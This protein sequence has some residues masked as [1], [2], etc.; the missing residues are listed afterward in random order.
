[1]ERCC[2]A[3]F[4]CSSCSHFAVTRCRATGGRD[5]DLSQT[6]MLSCCLADMMMLFHGRMRCEGDVPARGQGQIGHQ[7]L[8]IEVS[9]FPQA[10][11]TRRVCLHA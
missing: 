11:Q 6:P 5:L 10:A 3:I 8:C 1:M 7:T 4:D 2:A 9:H